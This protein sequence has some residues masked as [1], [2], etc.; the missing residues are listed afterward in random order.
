M[1][2]SKIERQNNLT[3]ILGLVWQCDSSTLSADSS[4]CLDESLKKRAP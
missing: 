4:E 1:K 2:L 3:M